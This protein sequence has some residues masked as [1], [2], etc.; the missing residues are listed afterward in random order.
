MDK[1]DYNTEPAPPP[2]QLMGGGTYGQE[3]KLAI[4]DFKRRQVQFAEQ[5]DDAIALYFSALYLAMRRATLIDGKATPWTVI[6]D[7][8]IHRMLS[9]CEDYLDGKIEQLPKK[10]W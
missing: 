3:F 1:T 2:S 4:E 7:Y 6:L 9:I 5:V 10:L 8:R